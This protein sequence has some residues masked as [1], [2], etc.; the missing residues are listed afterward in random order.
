[1][2]S[3]DLGDSWAVS[4]SYGPQRIMSGERTAGIGVAEPFGERCD[5][6]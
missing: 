3:S 4:L 5:T 1:M 2:A 6:P